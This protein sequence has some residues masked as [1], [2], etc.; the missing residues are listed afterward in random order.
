MLTALLLFAVGR[1]R[2]LNGKA[3]V[4]DGANLAA[5]RALLRLGP[6]AITEQFQSCP[7]AVARLEYAAFLRNSSPNFRHGVV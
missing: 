4:G 5:I 1:R 7:I 2:D 3:Q 6:E